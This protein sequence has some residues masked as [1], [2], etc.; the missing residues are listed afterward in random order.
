M[1]P[2]T[3]AEPAES[4]FKFVSIVIMM[5]KKVLDRMGEQMANS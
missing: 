3:V 2:S 1:V 4:L 5:G